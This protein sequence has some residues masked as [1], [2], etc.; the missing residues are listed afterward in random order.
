VQQQQQQA[1]AET[2]LALGQLLAKLHAPR[3]GNAVCSVVIA[4]V[5]ISFSLAT[6]Q[7]MNNS[8]RT[9]RQTGASENARK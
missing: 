1:A 3:H 2:K 5:F 8:W 4:R 9:C 6:T 7:L